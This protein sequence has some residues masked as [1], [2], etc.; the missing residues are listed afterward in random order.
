MKI[1]AMSAIIMPV[2]HAGKGLNQK[3]FGLSVTHTLL[4][5]SKAVQGCALQ[6]RHEKT[7]LLIT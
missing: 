5:A 1:H 3:D 6:I 4:N 2:L 7:T